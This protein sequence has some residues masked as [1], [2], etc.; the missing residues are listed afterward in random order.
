MSGERSDP[1]PD[2]LATSS[3]RIVESGRSDE[4]SDLLAVEEP[5]EVRVVVE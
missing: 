4:R 5:L 2:S 3:V 1:S